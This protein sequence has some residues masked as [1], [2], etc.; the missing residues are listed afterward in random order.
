MTG[1][2]AAYV[3]Q[4]IQIS[5]LPSNWTLTITPNNW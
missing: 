3:L 2:Y 1:N 5:F 4:I